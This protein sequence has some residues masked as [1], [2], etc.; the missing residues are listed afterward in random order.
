MA[1]QLRKAAVIG[2]GTMGSGIA[3]LLAGVGV[4]VILLDIPAKGTAPGDPPAQR[5]AIVLNNLAALSKSRPA[6]LFHPD[7][8][9]L[10]TPGNLE[11]NLDLLRD[12]DW[13]VE[14]IV[15]DLAIKR[16]LMARLEAVRHPTA[17]V[18]T[19]TSGLRI[20]DIAEG[21]SAEFQQHF[22]GTHFFN[23]PRYLKLLE[24]I[25]HPRTDPA[26]RQAMAD[27]GANVLGKGIVPCKDTPNF[28]ANRLLSLSGTFAVNY[29]L[30][31]GYTVAEVDALTGPLI[32]RPKT[33]TFR[34]FDL[35]GTDIMVHVNRNLYPAIP[36]DEA[37]EVLVHPRT[38]ALMQRMLDAG[39]LGNKAGQGFYKRVDKPDGERE[40]WALNLETLEYEPPQKVRFASVGEHRGIEDVGARIKALV[41]ADDRAGQFLWHLHAFTVTYA[42]R[43]LG[44]IADDI[45]A[46]DNATRWGFN[47]ALGPFEIWDAL[48][49]AE[50]IPRLEADGYAVAPWVRE[51]V[52]SGHPT[53]YRRNAGGVATHVYDRAQGDYVS[54]A[55]D[56]RAIAIASLRAEGRRL[57]GRAGA[58]LLDLGDGVLLL[59]FHT[60]AN[61]IDDD[62]IAMGWR[63][64]EYLESGSFEGL[65]VGNDG[66]HFSAGANIF[67][68]LML[69]QNG[70]YDRIDA[71]VRELQ[72]LFQAMRRAPRPVV[73]APFGMALGGGAEFL[74]AGQRVVAH[75]ELYAGLVEIGV[76][77][78]PAGSGCKEM[79]RR[80]LNPVMRT[81]NADPLPPLQAIFEQI[82]LA[83]V[84]ESARQARDMGFLSP[85]DRIL[86]NRDH[87]LAEAKREV[88]HLAASGH[89]PAPPETI[90]AAGRDALAALHLAVFTLQDGGYATEHD[91][92]I[93][94]HIAYVLCGG[95]LSEPAWVP[96]QY[97]L[98]L[99]REAFVALCHEPKTLERIAYMLQHNKPLRN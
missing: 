71:V 77:L 27:F 62:I 68:I 79:L 43:R 29:A 18:S 24:I 72:N 73:T 75:A 31:H 80:R 53:F 22:L 67:L 89:R 34:L 44:E 56:P 19:N 55:R 85:A 12:A 99:E 91:A 36:D 93:A 98:D 32:G 51:M 90:W 59:E 78:L 58:S 42:A 54:L 87:L 84:S 38:T 39:L 45:P 26:V 28:I 65:V 83:R 60:K 97:L 2:S 81:P 47:H 20:A 40:F 82:A 50:T 13:I 64:L 10:I 63:A 86:L 17:I 30:E 16:D 46:I 70:E 92:L 7:D 23:P 74:M 14:A 48:G 21:R 3:A 61:A 96:E 6:Q 76:G 11:D 1:Y 41:N 25:P 49:V 4:P 9:A 15:E 66:E 35:I 8:L 69:A 57:E 88:L 52:A 95:D 33:A 94:N 5:N 37:R